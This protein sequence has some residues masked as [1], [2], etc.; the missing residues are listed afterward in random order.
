MLYSEWYW[1]SH[2]FG[3][4]SPSFCGLLRAHHLQ[5]VTTA[6]PLFHSFFASLARSKHLLIISESIYDIMAW[7]FP[8]WHFFR[9]SLSNSRC[10]PTPGPSLIPCNYFSM[11]FIHLAFLFCS[12]SLHNLLQIVLLFWLMVCPRAFSINSLVELSFVILD[13]PVLFVLLDLIQIPFKSHLI[14]HFKLNYH[15][16]SLFCFDSFIPTYPLVFFLP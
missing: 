8:I 13:G 1:F 7:R 5:F 14:Y 12:F 2:W 15:L 9:V 11:L 4:L 10:I 6:T 3:V 16:C